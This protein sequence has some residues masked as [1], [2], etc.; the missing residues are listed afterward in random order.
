MERADIIDRVW[1]LAEPMVFMPK[2][3]FV[4]NLDGWDLQAVEINGCVAFVTAQ[5]GP[6]FHFNSL[7]GS[8]QITR[9]MIADFLQPII[10]RYGHAETRTPKDDWRQRRFYEAFGFVAVGE[11]YYDILYRI[12][13]IRGASC[14]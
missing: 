1:E 2:E 3:E 9:R 8:H 10:A 11:D 5:N 6:K 7:G 4:R 14:H 13:K 12:Q